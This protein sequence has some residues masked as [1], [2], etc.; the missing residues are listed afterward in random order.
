[1]NLNLKLIA[2]AGAILFSF[3]NLRAQTSNQTITP[4][5]LKAA[6]QLLI[7]IGI[8]KQFGGMMDNIISAS[9]NQ[10]PAEQ[11]AKFIDVMKSFMNKY[12]T[13]DLLKDKMAA[14]YAEEFTEDELNQISVFYSSPIG[15]K[16]SSKLPL[17]MQRGMLI[18]QEAVAEHK[19][20][21]TQMMQDAFGA[22]NQTPANQS[23]AKKSTSKTPA[24]H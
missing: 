13:W 6:E 11:R 9:S 8:D 14:I 4:S 7:S 19:D 17:L 1:M 20:E 23:P 16:V 18:G 3:S 24:K 21:L 22:S 2:L 10:I 15:Q 12:F 5:H